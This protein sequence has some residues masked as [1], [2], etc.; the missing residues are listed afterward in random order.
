MYCQTRG[1][2]LAN[3]QHRAGK[4]LTFSNPKNLSLPS[5]RMGPAFCSIF[6]RGV[7]SG[8]GSSN[9]F[10]FL[11]LV[12]GE[13]VLGLAGYEIISTLPFLSSALQPSAPT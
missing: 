2:Q 11:F 4:S 9:P 13:V 1:S 3:I 7:I 6:C 5:F 8:S 12:D 10:L